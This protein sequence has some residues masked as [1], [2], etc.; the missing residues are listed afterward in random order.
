ME[1]YL[2][3][4]QIID[5][6]NKVIQETARSLTEGQPIAKDRAK[7]L[8]YF[9]RDE[10][11]YNY[12]LRAFLP[13]HFLASAILARRE[14]LCL[15][16]A[17]L[18]AALAR[19]IG[20][21]ARLRVAIVRNHLAPKRVS[22]R[23]NLG[24]NLFVTHG[25]GELYI[26]GKW[27]K[28]APVFDPELCQEK[29]LVQVEFDGVYDALLPSHDLDGNRYIEYVDDRG[30]FHDLPLADLNRWRIEAYGPEYFERVDQAIAERKE[31]FPQDRL[32]YW[33]NTV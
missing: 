26:D 5:C 21:P 25:Y 14:G 10:I 11:R 27:V 7:S 3:P 13:E 18:I 23:I 15:M 32:R 33:T 24:S 22:D 16:K 19:A 31:R 30:I 1:Q 29:R 4:T 2:R 8:F 12:Y 6:D 28:V 9:V 20:M 17:V